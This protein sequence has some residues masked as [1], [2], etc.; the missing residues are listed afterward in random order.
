MAFM[1]GYGNHKPTESDIAYIKANYAPRAIERLARELQLTDKVVSRIVHQLGLKKPQRL[2]TE[3]E[4]EFFRANYG[5]LSYG[6]IA[7]ALNMTHQ[8]V[9]TKRG[10]L[11]IE[12]FPE[13]WTEERLMYLKQEG[14][15]YSYTQIANHLNLPA[16]IV[17][18]MG[19][20]LKIPRPRSPYYTKAEDKFIIDN[21]S[22]MTAE[23]I[24]LHLGRPKTGILHRVSRLKLCKTTEQFAQ[25]Q[26]TI[27]SLSD[28]YIAKHMA[29]QNPALQEQLLRYPE[30]LNVRKHEIVLNRIIRHVSKSNKS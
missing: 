4:I 6:Q 8:Q 11:G 21:Y 24:G 19:G 16:H 30:L 18:R 23:K 12:H 5:K 13:Y 7:Q 26:F 9:S 17:K 10:M 14:P 3:Q 29:R 20:L 27:G 2:W 1:T 28:R 22:S 25:L 15:K